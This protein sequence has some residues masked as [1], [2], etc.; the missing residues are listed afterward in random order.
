MDDG[1]QRRFYHANFQRYIIAGLLTITPL[2]AVWLVFNFFLNTLSFFGQP[3]AVPLTGFL[4]Q[5][6]PMA[7]PFV[8]NPTV[9]WLLA[10]LVAVLALY[11]IGAIAS[12]VIGQ[13]LIELF[14]RI[15]TRIPL[16]QT[17]YSAAKKL[18]DVL[19][20][21]PCSVDRLAARRPE[22]GRLRHAHVYRCAQRRGDGGRLCP[23]RAQPDLGLPRIAARVEADLCR[24]SDRSGDDHDHFRRGRRAGTDVGYA[25]GRSRNL[26]RLPISISANAGSRINSES[27]TMRRC[28]I[29]TRASGSFSAMQAENAGVLVL[30]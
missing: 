27:W 23:L 2:F 21:R 17:I 1:T 7:R 28:C 14:E 26:T 25:A 8:D 12:R 16:V 30:G 20:Q 6:L 19:H 18:V 4:D 22:N 10:V 11:F 29:D 9:R 5:N 15:I 13:R 3:L 24:H